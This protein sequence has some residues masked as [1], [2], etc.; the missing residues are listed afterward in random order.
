MGVNQK[1]YGHMTLDTLIWTPFVHHIFI[2]RSIIDKFVLIANLNVYVH[3]NQ[4]LKYQPKLKNIFRYS[5]N[6]YMQYSTFIINK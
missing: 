5:F 3:S 4:F 2:F 1:T 6:F